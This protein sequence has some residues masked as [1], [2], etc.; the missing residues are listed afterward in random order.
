MITGASTGIGRATA[1]GL[2]K[3]FERVTLVGRNPDRHAPVIDELARAGTHVEFVECEMAS[4]ES[5]AG[6]ASFIGPVDVLI[7]NAGVAGRRGITEDGFELHFGVNHLAHHLL[8]TELADRILDRVVVVS[9]NAHHEADGLDLGG[10]QRN[11]PS[12]A[13]IREYRHSKLANVLFGRQLAQRFPFTTVIVHPG[14]VATDIWRR[15]PWPVRPLVTRRMAPPEVGADTPC[16]AATAEGL[17]SGGYYSK[18]TLHPPSAP[19]RDDDAGERLWVRS[20][21]WVAGFR[22]RVA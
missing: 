11:T 21:E 1:G 6:A 5:V 12:F 8:V 10:V 15:L 9:S 4:L 16:W 3:D 14:L 18:R 7:A 17:A 2:A 22:R 19:A 13:G 20:E